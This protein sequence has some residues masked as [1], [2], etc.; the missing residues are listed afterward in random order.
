MLKDLTVDTLL[1]AKVGPKESV[2][3]AFATPEIQANGIPVP[4]PTTQMLEWFETGFT[5][6]STGA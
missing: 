3:Q 6:L 5:T 4:L 1:A 2:S